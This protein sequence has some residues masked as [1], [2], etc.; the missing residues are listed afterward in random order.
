M[1]IKVLMIKRISNVFISGIL[2]LFPGENC[3][4]STVNVESRNPFIE[5]LL[6]TFTEN[7]LF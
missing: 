3:D 7:L 2:C 1:R 6:S 4:D 5:F